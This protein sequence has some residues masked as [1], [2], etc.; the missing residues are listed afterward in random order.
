ME[1]KLLPA[2]SPTQVSLCREN[3][4]RWW[5]WWLDAHE[6]PRNLQKNASY[7]PVRFSLMTTIRPSAKAVSSSQYCQD[8]ALSGVVFHQFNNW[9]L[10][11]SFSFQLVVQVAGSI[12]FQLDTRTTHTKIIHGR[13]IQVQCYANLIRPKYSNPANLFAPRADDQ[14]LKFSGFRPCFLALVQNLF[15]N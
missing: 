8:Q 12:V 11:F 5:V 4:F 9:N 1:D 10:S 15:A 13:Y 3:P 6:H 7:F 14:S 2:Q